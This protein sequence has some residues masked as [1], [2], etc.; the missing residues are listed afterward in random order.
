M[1]LEIIFFNIITKKHKNLNHIL[2]ENI[3]VESVVKDE[4]NYEF[5]VLENELYLYDEGQYLVNILDEETGL[6]YAFEITI[7]TT[8]PT[9]ELVGVENGGTT[10]KVIVMK[11]VSEKPYSIYITVDGVPFEYK[12][13]EEIEKCGRFKVVLS[14][15]AGNTTTYEFERLY[16]LNGPSI[17][18][19]AGLGALVVLVIILLVKSR[20]NY[21]K[22]EVIEEET[23]ETVVEDDFNDGDDENP[24]ID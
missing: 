12:I 10:K 8:A 14:D 11:N 5:E 24:K 20:R 22:E 3:V 9:L 4:E 23:E 1:S 18:V 15:E 2:Q 21:Y 13:G 16:S 7:D 6:R 19:L 17:A